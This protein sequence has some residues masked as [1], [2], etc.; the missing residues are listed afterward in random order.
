MVMASLSRFTVPLKTDQSSPYQGL[1]MPKLQY[2][3]RVSFIGIGNSAD[4]IEMTKQVVSFNRPSVSFADTDIHVYNS[5]VRVAGKHTWADL[6]CSIRDDA[7]G[8]VSRLVGEQ[9]QKQFDF[10]E[11]SSAAAGGDYKFTIK[12]EMLD[13]G[14]GVHDAQILETWEVYGAYIKEA[15]YQELN[16]ANSDPVTIALTFRFDNA[17]QTS[18]TLGVG[19]YVPRVPGDNVTQ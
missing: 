16:Y 9:L 13:G 6:S 14:N 5:T 15:N 19:T 17:L 10:M 7:K 2:R 4:T 1:L 11:Q 12:C 18:G 8:N 3:F